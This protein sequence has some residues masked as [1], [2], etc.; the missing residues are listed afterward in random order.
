VEATKLV[1]ILKQNLQNDNSLT[2]IVEVTR[3]GALLQRTNEHLEKFKIEPLQAHLLHVDI[4]G[5]HRL[6]SALQPIVVVAAV[7]PTVVRLHD[8]HQIVAERVRHDL[9]PIDIRARLLYLVALVQL[10]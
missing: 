8:G 9:E 1:R 7:R 10:Q 3:K 2:H 4:P 6:I 5:G